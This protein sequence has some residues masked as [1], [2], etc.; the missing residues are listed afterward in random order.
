MTLGYYY[1]S[2]SISVEYWSLDAIKLVGIFPSFRHGTTVNFRMK[3][4]LKVATKAT[5]LLKLVIPVIIF[6]G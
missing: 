2:F 3:T 5:E 1:V 6:G 4:A